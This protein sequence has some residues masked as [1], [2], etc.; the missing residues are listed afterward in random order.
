[1]YNIYILSYSSSVFGQIFL[2][3]FSLRF[4]KLNE[5]SGFDVSVEYFFVIQTRLWFT[6]FQ[7]LSSTIN[8][9]VIN[10]TKVY[11]RTRRQIH[12]SN[13][14]I[15]IKI[16]IQ[17]LINRLEDLNVREHHTYWI[18]HHWSYIKRTIL[19]KQMVLVLCIYKW[20]YTHKVFLLNLLY[21]L[22]QQQQIL[23]PLFKPKELKFL[24]LLYSMW[25]YN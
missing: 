24:F 8:L 9:S 17:L 12:R 4:I 18:K 7:R 22:T 10:A 3:L 11:S 6:E 1:M 20:V 16:T 2:N 15:I 19:R 13:N 14:I 5:F 23:D 25:S 21:R